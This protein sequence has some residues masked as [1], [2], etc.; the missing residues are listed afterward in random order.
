[1]A[2]RGKTIPVGNNMGTL[3]K[4]GGNPGYGRGAGKLPPRTPGVPPI[5]RAPR[6]PGMGRGGKLT[7]PAPKRPF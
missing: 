5:Y 4:G 2:D 3:G 1:M 7:P 6:G